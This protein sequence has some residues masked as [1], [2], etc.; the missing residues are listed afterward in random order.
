MSQMKGLTCIHTDKLCV[1]TYNILPNARYR[2]IEL[3]FLKELIKTGM[4]VKSREATGKASS[5]SPM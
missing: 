4:K 2:V 5:L 1:S 3:F